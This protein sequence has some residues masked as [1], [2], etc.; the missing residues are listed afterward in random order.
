MNATN[1]Q[2]ESPASFLTARDFAARTA[3]SY[4]TVLRLIKRG[5]IRSL[6]FCRHKR[7]PAA[8]LARWQR[9]EF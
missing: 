2:S 5:K 9:G 8:E 3:L 4:Q 6:P 7:I 1:H